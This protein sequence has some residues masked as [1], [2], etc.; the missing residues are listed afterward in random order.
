MGI[1]LW[2]RYQ[3]LPL[4]SEL[5]ATAYGMRTSALAQ[6]VPVPDRKRSA[7]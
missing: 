1:R 6:Q 2:R 4:T 5:D 3:Y 7:A